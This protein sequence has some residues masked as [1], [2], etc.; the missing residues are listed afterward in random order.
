MTAS[1]A[2]RGRDRPPRRNLIAVLAIVAL[3]GAFFGY[4]Q[5]VIS[6]A[7]RDIRQ[8]FD[9]N[10]FAV[11]AA[12]SWVTAGALVGAL[13]GGHLADRIGRREHCGSPPPRSGWAPSCRRSRR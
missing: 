8:T 10:T 13:L 7:L 9:A 12:A 1:G 3:S 11:E 2:Q 5:G 6:G 4:D